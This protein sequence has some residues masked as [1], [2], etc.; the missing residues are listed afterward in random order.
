MKTRHFL[1]PILLIASTSSF[2]EKPS[3]KCIALDRSGNK[4]D[5]KNVEYVHDLI[6]ERAARSQKAIERYSEIT[7]SFNM[8]SIRHAAET[9]NL[10]VISEAIENKLPEQISHTLTLYI[11]QERRIIDWFD[12]SAT[13]NISDS[14]LL[15]E[16]KE[17]NRDVSMIPI[18]FAVELTNYEI[19]KLIDLYL[20]SNGGWQLTDQ[21]LLFS[22]EAVLSKYN[23]I[24]DKMKEIRKQEL[25]HGQKISNAD[26]KRPATVTCAG[27]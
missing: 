11:D 25:L 16:L 4:I 5:V 1:F 6:N 26:S 22:D 3:N 20:E 15:E 19:F 7:T 17:Y 23:Q 14:T 2:A 8:P 21:G 24:S 27:N 12:E 18:A 10:D 9:G 13:K